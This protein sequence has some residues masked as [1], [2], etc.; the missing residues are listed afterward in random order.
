MCNVA[1]PNKVILLKDAL[2][3]LIIWN[4]ESQCMLVLNMVG[5]NWYKVGLKEMSPVTERLVT[6]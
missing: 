6:F 4:K 1:V 3:C 2:R 5:I